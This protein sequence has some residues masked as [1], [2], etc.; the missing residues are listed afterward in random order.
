MK[1]I[2]LATAVTAVALSGCA[3]VTRGTKEV[4]FAD[5]IPT[6]AKL[7]TDHGYQCKTPCYLKLPRKN[8]FQVT[9]TKEGYK[10]FQT[11]VSN[12]ISGAGGAA[13]AG[14]V[15]VGGLI[16]VG[17][18]AVSGASLNL[19]PNPLY[20]ILAP[21]GSADDSHIDDKAPTAVPKQPKPR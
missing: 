21:V 14:N 13:L 9:I 17:V 7:T 10:D 16:G 6:D 12:S 15:L 11:R 20:V 5:S 3:T 8:P 2:I 1:A 4:W 19:N 18:D